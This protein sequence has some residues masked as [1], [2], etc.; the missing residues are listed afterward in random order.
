MRDT[1]ENYRRSLQLTETLFETGISSEQEVAQAKT[2]LDT[3][4][5]QATDL[6]VSRAQFEHAIATLI[7]KP[8]STFSLPV[9]PFVPKPPPV[10][11]ALP[12]QLLERRPDVAAAERRVAAAN[13]EVGV[14]KAAYYPNLTL[15]ATGG[16]ESQSFL[17][18]FNWPSRFWSVGP[19]MAETLLDFGVRRA[20]NEQAQA[21]Y[22]AAVGTY[23]QTVLAD[24]Q[25]V[26]DNLAALR[27]LS[28]EVGEQ[29]TAVNSAGRYLD[30]S[31]TRY[32]TGVD[33]YLNVITAQTT[34]LTN[35]ETEVQIQLREMTS[36]VALIMAMG[37][38]WDVS[39][40]PKGKDMRTK[41][42]KWTPN[43]PAQKQAGEVAPANPPPLKQ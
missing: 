30:L 8:A 43:G 23:R 31:L 28:E 27:I 41:A 19:Q 17:Q 9:A 5:A 24:F 4:T 14:A 18:W 22:D 33:S 32:K 37:G 26:E 39:Q 7:G 12:S 3:A 34:V 13:A 10:P 25:A 35:R 2:Q 20:L 40:L 42:V 15:N 36:S 38:G 21:S 29:H 1:L 16:F 11:V 6:G